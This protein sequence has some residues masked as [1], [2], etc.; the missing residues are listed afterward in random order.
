MPLAPESLLQA[1]NSP[2]VPLTPLLTVVP[3]QLLA[4]HIA[5]AR[6]CDVDKQSTSPKY[7]AG[8]MVGYFDKLNYVVLWRFGPAQRNLGPDP[9]MNVEETDLGEHLHETN[10]HRQL[11]FTGDQKGDEDGVEGSSGTPGD[12]FQ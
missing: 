12:S 5:V 1:R 10:G 2:L 11:E 3:L 4:Y 9:L 8:S 7:Y 6:G